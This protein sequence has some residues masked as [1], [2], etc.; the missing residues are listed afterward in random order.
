MRGL[1]LALRARRDSAIQSQGAGGGKLR[2]HGT[3]GRSCRKIGAGPVS[4]SEKR[5][6][7]KLGCWCSREERSHKLRS[8]V[9]FLQ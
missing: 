5:E 9:I 1:G 2:A 8:K 4:R 7:R 6:W 3:G